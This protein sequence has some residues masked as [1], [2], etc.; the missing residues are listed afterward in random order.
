M[1]DGERPSADSTLDE[2]DAAEGDDAGEQAH[3]WEAAT[4]GDGNQLL[5]HAG[6]GALVTVG[7]VFLVVSPLLGGLIAGWTHR[8]EGVR[9]GAL[10]GALAM[11]PIG[12]V[13]VFLFVMLAGPG[14][15]A[16]ESGLLAGLAAF[17]A[18]AA[19]RIVAVA[20]VVVALSTVGGAVGAR[21]ARPRAQVEPPDSVD[22]E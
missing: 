15:A 14:I 6:Y 7:L 20:G 8:E 4:R 11:A 17:V 9:I 2:R 18:L 1:S 12:V 3:P 13:M 16:S 10:S 19:P 5:R 21:L 22:G